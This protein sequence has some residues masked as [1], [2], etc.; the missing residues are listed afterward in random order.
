MGTS[1]PPRP[2]RAVFCAALALLSGTGCLTGRPLPDIVEEINATLTPDIF[3]ASRG[4]SIQITFRSNPD[5]NQTV[6]IRKDGKAS[7]LFLGEVELIGYTLEQLEER[8][9]E[10]YGEI[11][12]LAEISVQLAGESPDAVVLYGTVRGIG[13][14]SLDAEPLSLREALARAG[15]GQVGRSNL[16]NTLL[17]R[18]MPEERHYTYWIIDVSPQYWG[19]P[20]PLW[21]QAHDLVYV[22]QHPI[23]TT[24][25]WMQNVLR[26]LPFPSFLLAAAT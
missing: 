13:Q 8:L 1:A 4:D 25:Q 9:K 22:P 23:V 19:S 16:A 7:L 20:K 17:V 6:R 18:W 14:M 21:L 11:L 3:V 2:L 5:L 24:G 26:L 15:G 10:L 12:T